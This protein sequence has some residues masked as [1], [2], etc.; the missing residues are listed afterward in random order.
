MDLRSVVGVCCSLGG[1]GGVD[2]GGTQT[3]AITLVPKQHNKHKM[4]MITMIVVWCMTFQRII[5]WEHFSR[6]VR[7][8]GGGCMHNTRCRCPAWAGFL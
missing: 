4:T 3:I 1:G 6:G 8:G 2:G 5:F 7:G